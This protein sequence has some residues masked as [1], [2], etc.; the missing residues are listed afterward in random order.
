M[1]YITCYFCKRVYIDYTVGV[2][3]QIPLNAGV[4]TD[5]FHNHVLIHCLY[6]LRE[7]RIKL[8]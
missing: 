6:S 1:L 3:L 4:F 7:D 2:D 8:F 5:S